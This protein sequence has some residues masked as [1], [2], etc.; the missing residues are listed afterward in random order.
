MDL[1]LHRARLAL[2][3]HKPAVEPIAPVYDADVDERYS[4]NQ[5]RQ[6]DGKFGSKSAPVGGS[7]TISAG[8]QAGTKSTERNPVDGPDGTDWHSLPPGLQ[9]AQR[10]AVL[11]AYPHMG[12]GGRDPI[13]TIA[14]NVV[15]AYNT[16]GSKVDRFGEAWYG[17]AHNDCVEISQNTGMSLE[18]S[19]GVMAALSPRTAWESNVVWAHHLTD[20]VHKDAPITDS[21]LD[22]PI[23]KS[24]MTSK[25]PV[26]QTVRQWAHEDGVTLHPGKRLS[27]HSIDEQVAI[28]RYAGQRDSAK[29]TAPRLTETGGA[30]EDFKTT[31]P[32]SASM[33][34]ALAI[35]HGDGSRESVSANLNGHKVRSFYNDIMTGGHHGSVTIDAHA[36]DAAI[37][38]ATSTR[39]GK[40]AKNEHGVDPA[41]VLD[42]AVP[43]AP[44]GSL[45][46]HGAQ[47][48]YALFAEGFRRATTRVNRQRALQGLPPLDPPQV[49]AIAWIATLAPK[50]R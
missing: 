34:N 14:D 1:K 47:G 27:E 32:F 3:A 33:R 40:K 36:L 29:L 19:T 9:E 20:M 18:A 15:D 28:V 6:K 22:E 16:G 39:S 41:K 8:L 26:T 45:K 25:G 23:T 35:A 12:A 4:P 37:I 5:P 7:G 42:G 31:P 44:R 48:T 30:G 21:F 17:Q 43:G 2:R 50:G 38:G 24:T 13:D 46:K 10:N 49:Q 11:A